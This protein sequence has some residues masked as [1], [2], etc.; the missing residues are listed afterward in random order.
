MRAGA[1]A[2]LRS[3]ADRLAPRASPPPKP[4]SP[5]PL[6]RLGGRWWQ[7]GEIVLPETGAEALDDVHLRP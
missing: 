7:R 3:L 6:I 4:S 1:A 5:A 2:R